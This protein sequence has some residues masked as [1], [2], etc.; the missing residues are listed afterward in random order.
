MMHPL[1]L[2]S[3]MSTGYC[4]LSKPTRKRPDGKP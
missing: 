1:I 4:L 2:F 3:S